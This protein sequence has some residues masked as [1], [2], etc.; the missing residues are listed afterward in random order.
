MVFTSSY[1]ATG[2]FTGPAS[3]FTVWPAA[4]AQSAVA[5]I[6]RNSFNVVATSCRRGTCVNCTGSAVSN[7]AHSSGRAAFLAPEMATSP[8]KGRPP[9]MR[10]LS[11][12]WSVQVQVRVRLEVRLR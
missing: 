4:S 11:M 3:M 1:G 10:S 5:P 12:L 6:W 7:A 9:R 8:C 2:L